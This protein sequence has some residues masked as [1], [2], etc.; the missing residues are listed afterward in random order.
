MLVVPVAAALN[1][2][3]SPTQAIKSDG[4]VVMFMVLP[5]VTVKGITVKAVMHPISSE[6]DPVIAPNGTIAVMLVAV[7]AV[8]VATTPLNFTVLL[9][10]VVL[11]F[12]PV[13]VT[14]VPTGP[15]VGEKDEAVN[16]GK[17]ETV[18]RSIE[19]VLPLKFVATMSGL[20]FPSKS[21]IARPYG[22][23]VELKSI[24]L[25]KELRLMGGAIFRF[26]SMAILAPPLVTT[27]SG[28]PS[29]SI[30]LM[31]TI[32]EPAPETKST[33]DD[34]EIEPIVLVF[35]NTDTDPEL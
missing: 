19:V 6:I 16:A 9:I 17:E 35:P 21:P 29:P 15:L 3:I 26:L 4:W 10:G 33:F 20:P 30:S 7:L 27:K 13:I 25:A 34:N 2:A 22:S 8:T 32:R 14:L 24:L 12:I 23:E 1:D 31:L 28:I 18:L 5:L 11:K